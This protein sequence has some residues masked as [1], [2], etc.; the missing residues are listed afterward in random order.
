MAG[1]RPRKPKALHD[2]DGN[3]SKR[4]VPEDLPLSGIPECP[5]TLDA[6]AAAHFNFITAELSTIGVVK[7]LD[8]ESLSAL[9]NV[10]SD[11][12]LAS[13]MLK[14][15]ITSDD[16]DAVKQARMLK[17]TALRA[18]VSMASKFGLTPADRMKIMAINKPG[19]KKDETEERF[20]GVVG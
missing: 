20:F 3:P 18:W 1:G 9:A 13:E 4:D 2:L 7:R 5:S 11:F 10:W 17:Y 14:A 19:H 8:T 15:A 6:V 12:W 16:V